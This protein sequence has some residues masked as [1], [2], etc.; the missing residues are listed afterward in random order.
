MP[1]HALSPLL[2]ARLDELARGG[3]LKGREGVIRA[4]VPASAGHGPRYL[5]EGEDTP[6]LRLNSNG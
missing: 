2:A 6:F 4:V 3:R 5:I 1:T